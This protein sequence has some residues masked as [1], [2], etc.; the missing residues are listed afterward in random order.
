MGLGPPPPRLPLFALNMGAFF[1]MS[2]RMKNLIMLPRMKICSTLVTRPSLEVT[3][4]FCIWQFM[5]S[6]ASKSL[7][8]YTSP[9]TVSS[10]M[11]WPSASWRS[12]MGIPMD[13][14]AAF[15][16]ND[17]KRCNDD[18]KVTRAIVP[19]I[20]HQ[21]MH[22]AASGFA[23]AWLQGACPILRFC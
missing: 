22:I 19:R 11:M 14:I 16:L 4:R 15:F 12:L 8:L 20:A 18:R 3:V 23:H 5:L 1:N 7:P 17:V 9:V 2:G 13:I 10:V 21:C 6:S